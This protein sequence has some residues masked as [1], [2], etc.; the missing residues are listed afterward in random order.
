M[1]QA[2]ADTLVASGY[3]LRELVRQICNS[4]T[5]Q[6]STQ[7][8]ET[9]GD[10]LKYFSRAQVRRMRAEALLDSISQITATTDRFPRLPVGARSVQI[11]DGAV[12][13][14]FLS[15]FGRAPRETVCACEVDVQPNLSQ[16]FH[17]LNGEATNDKVVDGGVIDSLLQSGQSPQGV[18]EHMYLLCYSRTPT[19]MENEQLLATIDP[20]DPTEGLNDVF[21]ALLNSKEFIFN[22]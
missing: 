21:W 13:N 20:K 4:R 12:S 10:D 19:Q 1:L 16:A 7:P 6:L 5:Y 22:H 15:T 9:N 14:Y 17:L 8:N 3:D 2:L 11:A 18:I